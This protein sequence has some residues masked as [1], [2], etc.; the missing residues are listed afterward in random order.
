VFTISWV[1]SSRLMLASRGGDTE[2]SP[3]GL[4]PLE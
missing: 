2:P 4:R 3:A 1:A